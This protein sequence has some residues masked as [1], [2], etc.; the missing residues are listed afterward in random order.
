MPKSKPNRKKA[1][2]KQKR[3]GEE[4]AAAAGQSATTQAIVPIVSTAPAQAIDLPL[5]I[6]WR[7]F[8]FFLLATEWKG[9]SQLLRLSKGYFDQ[10]L[11]DTTLIRNTLPHIRGGTVSTLTW[12][13]TVMYRDYIPERRKPILSVINGVASG[14]RFD[15]EV[16]RQKLR[17]VGPIHHDHTGLV[18]VDV[19][20]I[21][22]GYSFSLT[23]EVTGKAF[24]RILAELKRLKA[25]PAKQY[26]YD[27]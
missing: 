14:L 17:H 3:K 26:E 7:I 6:L 20:N 9:W 13:S 25:I 8:T 1:A 23:A 18:Y 24:M 10:F 19:L 12:L 2:R 15:D 22:G 4:A 11:I 5:E 16:L 27:R 21:A